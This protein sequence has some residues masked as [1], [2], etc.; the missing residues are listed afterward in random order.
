MTSMLLGGP[1]HGVRYEHVCRIAMITLRNPLCI[2]ILD[3]QSQW[4]NNEITVVKLIMSG[5]KMALQLC[6]VKSCL[7][8]QRI[9]DT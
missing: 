4:P 2:R 9:V 3:H 1:K 8:R 5:G 7:D 6:Y